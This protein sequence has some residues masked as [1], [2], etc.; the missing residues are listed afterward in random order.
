[1]PRPRPFSLLLAILLAAAF[2]PAAAQDADG[3]I[4]APEDL[5]GFSYLAS[6]YYLY[7]P[8]GMR[9]IV[10]GDYASPTDFPPIMAIVM[11]TAFDSED[12]AR[13]AF[14][15]FS[16]FMAGTVGE[17]LEAPSTPVAEATPE[18]TT[19]E[20]ARVYRAL[21]TS[22]DYPIDTTTRT[23][24]DGPAIYLVIAMSANET[25]EAHSLAL[26]EFMRSR[27]LADEEPDFW[28]TG[29]STGGPFDLFPTED[30]T[31]LL[32]GM[33]IRNDHFRSVGEP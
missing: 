24:L 7:S 5:D 21:D 10:T 18:G 17:S 29:E 16:D 9:E 22:E 6:R 13:N 32:G 25:S 4:S 1:V 30:D 8:A 26:M 28:P 2:A 23:V 12:A 11:V 33:D 15:P 19:A 27:E 20:T 14:I 31:D 3:E